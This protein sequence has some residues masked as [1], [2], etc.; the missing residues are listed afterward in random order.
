MVKRSLLVLLVVGVAAQVLVAPAAQAASLKYRPDAWIK[1]C[2][3]STGCT[4]NPPPHPWLG[5]NIYNSTGYHQKIFQKIDN[6]EGVRYWIN[7]Q[8]DG[9]Q[10][11]TYLLH[12]CKGTKNFL[13]NA[14][15]VGKY[16]VP[17]GVGVDHITKQF[18]HNTY[19]FTLKPGKHLAITLNIVTVNANRHYTCPVTITSQGDST[20]TDTVAAVMKTF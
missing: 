6:G 10:K 7:F 4:I 20:K 2:G 12:G 19:K 5:N 17:Q 15:L 13:I 1:L 9:T 14:V 11:D 16:K 3:Q 8:N 18:I